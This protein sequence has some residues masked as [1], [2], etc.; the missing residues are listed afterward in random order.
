MHTQTR[1][2]LHLRVLGVTVAAIIGLTSAIV[3]TVPAVAA[4]SGASI[5]SGGTLDWGFKKSFRNYVPA[6]G[7]SATDGAT[8]QSDGTFRFTAA[9]GTYDAST[10]K[11]TVNGS[12]K[13][14][15]DYRAHTFVI[16]LSDPT[17][18]LTPTSGTMTAGVDV[19]L[20]DPTTGATTSDPGTKRIA[21]ATID[22]T[23][24]IRAVTAGDYSWTDL[25]TTITAA[26]AA[27][28]A[29]DI[30]GGSNPTQFYSAGTALDPLSVH[31][32]GGWPAEGS[33]PDEQFSEPGVQGLVST[34]VQTTAGDTTIGRVTTVLRDTKHG[35]VVV[36]VPAA[37]TAKASYLV[38]DDG[39]K[40]VAGPIDPGVA[41]SRPSIDP[42]TGNIVATASLPA[43]EFGGTGANVQGY[44]VVERGTDAAYRNV[45]HV[46]PSVAVPA[47]KAFSVDPADGSIV[48]Q[49]A[50][51]ANG[52]SAGLQRVAATDSDTSNP[53]GASPTGGT[54][55]AVTRT[56]TLIGSVAGTISSV[57]VDWTGKRAVSFD[58][59]AALARVV[60]L[61]SGA[62]VAD[63]P[64]GAAATSAAAGG[65]VVDSQGRAWWSNDGD[66]KLRAVALR[67]TPAVTTT[68]DRD[69]GA[70]FLAV[71]ESAKRLWVAAPGSADAGNVLR[72]YP[73]DGSTARTVVA[74]YS[75]GNNYTGDPFVLTA[76][77]RAVLGVTNTATDPAGQGLRTFAVVTTP[78]FTKQP[79]DV[80]VTL[81]GATKAA[82][83]TVSGATPAEVRFT[84][85]TTGSPTPT[86][87]WQKQTPSGWADVQ[88]GG[89]VSGATTSTL[90]ITATEALNGDRYRAIATNGIG[91]TV[92]GRVASST[93]T[94]RVTVQEPTAPTDPGGTGGSTVVGADGS[95]TGAKNARGASTNV[96]P[97][98]GLTTTAAG[99]TLTVKGSAFSKHTNG[100]GL[101]VLFGYVTK[102][103]SAGGAAGNGYDY[104]PGGGSG[105]QDGQ[106]FVAW[107]D[108]TGTGAAATA[109]FSGT[110]NA[111]FTQ[112]GVVAK[113][114]FTGQSTKRVDCLSGAVQCGII[115]I[116][117]HGAQDAALETF[118]PVYFAG[119]TVPGALPTGP[120]SGGGNG[121]TTVIQPPVVQMPPAASAP[122]IRNAA[123][124]APP[125]KNPNSAKAPAAA[126]PP[127]APAADSDELQRK[128]EAGEIDV[129]SA[130]DAGLPEEVRAGDE[131]ALSLAWSGEDTG[132]TAWTYSEPVQAGDFTVA[133][134]TATGTVDTAGLSE[135]GHHV[136]LV[137]D[138]GT[139]V[140]VPFT[141]SGASA[142]ATTDGSEAQVAAA[143]TTGGSGGMSTETLLLV[144]IGFLAGLVVLAIG[145]VVLLLTGVLQVRTRRKAPVPAAG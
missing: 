119:Q 67:G 145:L 115:T 72:A 114:T 143:S 41:T 97:A 25:P 24:G 13:V 108:N 50:P 68:I 62:L 59:G 138:R 74:E 49:I 125:A 8:K 101:Y 2:P 92:I 82:D 140:A 34:G 110:V 26:G 129:V 139:I 17:I 84:A 47:A 118:T 90:R 36:Q 44:V 55:R 43:A 76:D 132:G 20:V 7:Q 39:G 144:V 56:A 135:G 126:A 98:T 87:Q 141:V 79:A 109:K 64:I 40:R 23:K 103:P 137:G 10:R 80:A 130:S 142:A 38:L 96:K 107:P 52:G 117:A 12:G 123:V 14:V 66:G 127:T 88:D 83:G 11:L 112:S 128:I 100:S 85:T 91:D 70:A 105:G 28:F 45:V 95:I 5:V 29:A 122:T 86:L 46:K 61:T 18:E 19:R 120:T 104:I 1:P 21:F 15:F 42:S 4:G 136:V 133:D 81:T 102:Y 93:A 116:G 65:T 99:S 33:D 3:G 75:P 121:G 32:T 53:I 48:A 134:G 30:T 54:V 73:I 58:Q 78:A 35:L 124:T 51:A 22:V 63:V 77:G 131:L 27:A 106:G 113:A 9:D 89:S 6:A 71:D 31:V 60:D 111:G 69:G 37:G 94:L 57:G 16:T